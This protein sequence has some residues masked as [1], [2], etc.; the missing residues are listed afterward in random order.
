MDES[1]EPIKE[2]DNEPSFNFEA[3]SPEHLEPLIDDP[4]LNYF[5]KEEFESDSSEEFK[6]DAEYI[7]KIKPREERRKS[8]NAVK[9]WS[10]SFCRE[11]FKCNK[12][13]LS[14]IREH[15]LAKVKAP[16]QCTNCGRG[17]F[18]ETILRSHKCSSQTRCKICNKG[19]E[20]WQALRLH[21]KADHLDDRKCEKCNI[22]LKSASN[23]FKYY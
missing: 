3:V 13:F 8:K 17:Y 12:L 21:L 9:S 23:F 18:L 5:E 19:F 11:D 1:T 15:K 4:P 10:C 6:R 14:H 16:Y 2:E 20:K 7:P 22:E